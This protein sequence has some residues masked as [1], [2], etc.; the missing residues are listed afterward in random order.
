MAEPLTLQIRVSAIR[1]IMARREG[2]LT[3]PKE[4]DLRARIWSK[5]RDLKS[6]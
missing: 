6:P 1:V 3:V 5:E 2:V 4:G